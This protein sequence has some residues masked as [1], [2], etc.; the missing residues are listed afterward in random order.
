MQKVSFYIDDSGVLHRNSNDDIFV[1]AGY[2]FLSDGSRDRARNRYRSLNHEIKKKLNRKDE[3]KGSN[4]S[5]E[6]KRALFNVMKNERSFHLVVNINEL[7]DYILKDNKSITRYKNYIFKEM[8]VKILKDL[9]EEDVIYPY[10]DL[11][12]NI[13]VDDQLCCIDGNYSIEDLIYEE[14]I[15]G[16]HNFNYTKKHEPIYFGDLKVKTRFCDSK[17][18]YLI[19][20]SDILA[21]RIFN[22]YR[23]DKPEWRNKNNHTDLTFP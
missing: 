19:Q 11:D 17:Y 7:D 6:N 2:F 5:N 9:I 3:L 15:E 12:L 1:Y 8:I 13:N 14:M 4:L 23:M 21:N 16:I 18:D 22:S 20:A 10:N